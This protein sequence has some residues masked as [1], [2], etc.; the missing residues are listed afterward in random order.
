[1]VT[2]V[3]SMVTDVYSMVTDVYSMVTDVY[4]MVAGESRVNNPQKLMKK[5]EK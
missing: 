1:M 2:D 4:P 3:Y 5:S